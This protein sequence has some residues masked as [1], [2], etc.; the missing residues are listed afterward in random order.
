M[1]GGVVVNTLSMSRVTC[2][3]FCYRCKA[4]LRALL[5]FLHVTFTKVYA[6]LLLIMNRVRDQFQCPF[7]NV[8]LRFKRV[9]LKTRNFVRPSIVHSEGMSLASKSTFRSSLLPEM[10]TK[11]G[12][13]GAQPFGSENE[14]IRGVRTDRIQLWKSAAGQVLRIQI[15]YRNGF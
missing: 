5:F 7:V 4:F 14:E 13:A 2:E 10:R 1:L 11:K 12:W 15:R 6:K 3:C 9:F 8:T